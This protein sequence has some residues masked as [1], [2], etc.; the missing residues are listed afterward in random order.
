MSFVRPVGFADASALCAMT[1]ILTKEPAIITHNREQIAYLLAEAAPIEHGLM[2]CYL[3]AAHTMK[4]G[5]S[6]GLAEQ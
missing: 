2:C 5:A 1:A 3:Y 4:R 6:A